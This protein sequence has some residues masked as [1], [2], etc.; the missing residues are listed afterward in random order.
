MGV[1]PRHVES[2]C[3][4]LELATVRPVLHGMATPNASAVFGPAIR[5]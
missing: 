4:G 2:L 1:R 5:K 3:A